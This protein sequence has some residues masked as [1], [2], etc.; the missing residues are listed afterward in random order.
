MHWH[1]LCRLLACC[2]LNSLARLAVPPAL[3][4]GFLALEQYLPG[5][6]LS[7]E[8]TAASCSLKRCKQQRPYLA[9]WHPVHS[10]CRV[11]LSD[12]PCRAVHL[13]ITQSAFAQEKGASGKVCKDT[14][15]VQL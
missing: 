14:F 10:S 13:R 8:Q 12:S 9:M 6:A 4:R 11:W 15:G 2:T 7:A 3:P 1:A 5:H